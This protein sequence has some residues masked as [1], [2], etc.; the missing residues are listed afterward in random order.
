MF[1][2]HAAVYNK[3]MLKDILNYLTIESDY[4]F[5][6]DWK[7]YLRKSMGSFFKNYLSDN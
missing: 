3:M 5:L 4:L 2:P 6:K 1:F 7:Q